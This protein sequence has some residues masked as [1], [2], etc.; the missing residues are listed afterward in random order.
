[1]ISA[2][3][4]HRTVT[5]IQAAMA[6]GATQASACETLGLSP[7][8]YQRWTRQ[9]EVQGDCRP[10]AQRRAPANKLSDGVEPQIV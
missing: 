9:G 10:V 5:L 4:R 2:S 3:D 6:A 7:R 1:M 8:T